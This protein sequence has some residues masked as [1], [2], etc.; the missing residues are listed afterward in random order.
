MANSA[1]LTF[2]YAGTEFTRKYEF[3]GLTDEQ[4][5]ALKSKVKALNASIA[6]GTDGNL[7]EFFISDDYD[8]SD[9]D[10]VIGK[11]DGIVAAQ[12]KMATVTEIDLD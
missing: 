10:N 11:F 5:T 8:A 2:G 12:Y 4:C 6:G 3:D 1:T 9:P 7:S